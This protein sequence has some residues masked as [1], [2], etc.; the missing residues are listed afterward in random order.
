MFP[1]GTLTVNIAGSTLLGIL[2]AAHSPDSTV[3]LLVG[4]GFCGAL[5][6]FSSF[7][8]ETYRLS[9]EGA[10][11]LSVANVAGSVAV[12]FAAAWLGWTLTNALV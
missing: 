8:W 2:A 6:T 11:L 1:W 4:V 7:A 12:C 5:T 3:F 9:Q 10:T